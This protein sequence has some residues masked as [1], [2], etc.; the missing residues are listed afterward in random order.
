MSNSIICTPVVKKFTMLAS[1]LLPATLYA[2]DYEAGHQALELWNDEAKANVPEA[3]KIWLT[4][5]MV[6]FVSGLIFVWKHVPARWVVGGV[7]LSVGGGGL[8]AE[9][10]GLVV[11][12]G[13]VALLHLIFWSPGL[14]FLIRE[15]AISKGVSLYSVWAAVTTL[16]IIVSFFFDIRDASIYLK[17][18]LA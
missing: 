4:V 18:M 13:Y 12:S 1:L 6:T 8:I 7:L 16:V 11:L 5:M 3:V 2:A 14:F 17:H 10:L 15:R 9:A